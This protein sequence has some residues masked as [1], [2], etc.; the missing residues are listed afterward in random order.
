[1]IGEV[2]RRALGDRVRTL[3]AWCVG[4]AA[5]L[6]MIVAVYP[7]IRNASGISDL[8]KHYPDVLKE[9]FGMGAGIN[10][11][12]AAGYLDTELFSLMLPLFLLAMAIG[13][14]AGTLAGEHEAGLLELVV[15][16][17]LKRGSVVVAKAVGLTVELAALAAAMIVTLLIAGPLADMSLDRPRMAAAVLAAALLALMHGALALAV[18]AATRHRASAIGVPA[19]LAAVGYLVAGLA[20]LADWLSPFRYLSPFHYAGRAPLESGVD[21]S[22]LIVLAIVTVVLVGAAATLFQ[23]RDMASA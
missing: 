17:P 1:V 5:Y 19:A 8:A 3:A 6:A 22:G 10:L 11:A 15:A 7:S 20:G 13:T 9:L 16:A 4:A 23:R 18:G 14:G 12:S 21:A 2:L